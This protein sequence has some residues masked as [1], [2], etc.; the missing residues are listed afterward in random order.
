MIRDPLRLGFDP[1]GVKTQPPRLESHFLTLRG[2]KTPP[3]ARS[4]RL[5]A[6]ISASRALRKAVSVASSIGLPFWRLMKTRLTP[7][8]SSS[9]SLLL[10]GLAALAAAPEDGL[11]T[12]TGGLGWAFWCEE[13]G[14][15][16]WRGGGGA[17]AAASDPLG[18]PGCARADEEE[19]GGLEELL[20]GFLDPRGGPT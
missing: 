14:P 17:A 3:L 13:E 20:A 5:K 6:D 12:R 18:G 2:T 19:D 15:A 10:L 11:N 7:S 8:S 1:V 16:G 9:C 4:L